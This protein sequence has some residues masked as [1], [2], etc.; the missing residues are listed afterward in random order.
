M[1]DVA[2]EAEPRSGGISTIYLFTFFIL[3]GCENN[4]YNPEI[5]ALFGQLLY[6]GQ[7]NCRSLKCKAACG[8]R[9]QSLWS[10]EAEVRWAKSFSV[11]R[12]VH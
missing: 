2:Q 4:L 12:R 3:S 11:K 7:T 9:A 8:Q 5:Q 6:S 1:L 10:V